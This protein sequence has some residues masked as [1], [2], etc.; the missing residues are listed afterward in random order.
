M[1]ENH[2]LRILIVEDVPS[3]AELAERELRKSGFQFTSVRVDT[4]EG[5]L[6][7]LEEFQ[8][9]LVISDYAMPEFDGMQALMLSLE[10]DA[11]LPFIILTGSM[12]EETAV[13]CMKAGATDYVIKD[14]LARLPF[15]VREALETRKNLLE[16]EAAEKALAENEKRY[17]QFVETAREG[18][19]SIDAEGRTTFV[20]KAMGDMLGYEPAEMLGRRAVKFMFPEDLKDHSKKM[21]DRKHGRDCVYERRFLRK[22]GEALWTIVSACPL[23]DEQGHFAGSFAMITDITER[24]QA[25]EALQI[26]EERNRMA[27]AIGHVG[28]WEYDIQTTNFW[29]SDESKRIY[30]YDPEQ[31]DFSTDEVEGRIPERERVHQALVDLIET[32][33]PYN[34]EFEIHPRNGAGPRIIASIAELQRNEHGDPLKVIGCIQDITDRRRAEEAL[35]SKQ[36]ML[37]RTEGIA[38]IGSWAW[39]I[40]TDKVTWSDELFRIFQRDPREGAPSFDDHPAFYHP[41]DMARLRQ[42]VEAAITDGTSYELELRAIRKDGEI[43]VCVARGIPEMDLGGRVVS[44]YGSLQDIT[45]RRRAEEALRESEE[46]FRNYLENAPDGV[47][48]SDLEGTFLYGNRKCEE[49]IGYRREELIGKNFL[50]LNLLPEKSLNLAVKLLQANMEGRSTGPDE[51]ELISKGGRLIPVEINTSVVQ[52]MGQ[53]IVLSFARDITDRKQ[54]EEELR[55]SERRFMKVL[56]S[57]PDAV[58]LIDGE[59]FVDC[60]EATARMLGYAGRNEF[61]QTHPSELSPPVQPDGKNSFE[62][63]NEMMRIASERGFHQFEW[64]HRRADGEGFP[65]EVSLTSI[66]FRGKNV[67]HCMWRDLTERKRNE[68]ILKQTLEDLRKAVNATIQVM[69]SA[70]EVRDPYTAG[71]QNRVAD[72][73]RVIAV[74][75]GLPPNIIDG[76][77]MA[78]SIHDIGKLSVPAEILSKPSKLT[79][80]EFALIKEHSRNGY[81]MLKEVESPWPLAEIVYQHHERMDGSGY[82]RNLKGEEIIME[83]R[84]MAV[85]DV[86]ESMASHRPYR[87]S[88]G[89][90]AALDE[91]E[92]NRGTHYDNAVADVCLRLFREK[93]YQLAVA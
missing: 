15:A 59:K 56:Y 62:K 78:G 3:D 81:E 55:E 38:H 28:S 66:V 32:D 45:N 73:A 25:G 49:I 52:R 51:I 70:V 64:E 30:G 47:Y 60:N 43:R 65:V 90:D 26:S 86:V 50:E 71:H 54:A 92:K 67:I 41:E 16:K 53:R 20:N 48:L 4:K 42:A 91:I 84:I 40:A 1:D 76:I 89:I 36:M 35:R 63:A 69:V 23:H 75:M 31:S 58:L 57:S 19:W 13:A 27:Q 85:A 83:A 8:P 9:H 39:N 17:R 22:D 74:E 37:A 77:R 93:G 5:F 44:L 80:I 88:L 82:P 46:L 21:E 7:A 33:K 87:P 14:H 34:L 29:G 18:V 68:E 2:P 61:L 12:N 24:K 6:K 72:L 11:G 79:S 10:R